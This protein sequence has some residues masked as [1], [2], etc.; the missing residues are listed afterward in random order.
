MNPSLVLIF[1]ALFT[2]GIGEGTFMYFQ[3]I[4][5]QNLGAD[6]VAIGAILSSAGLAM[7]ISH[8]PAGFLSDRIGRRPLLIAAWLIGILAALLMAAASALPLFVVGLLLYG[9]TAFV[10]SPLSSYVTAAR[11]AWS[12]SRALSFT[13]AAFNVGAV[14]GPLTGGW[15]GEHF[16]LRWVFA[17]AAV[18]FVVSTAFLVFIKPQPLDHHD[19]EAPPTDLWNN[20]RYLGFIALVFVIIFAMY[21]PQ[22]LT[23][24][25][26]Q[27]QR[28]LTLQQIGLLG[29]VAALGNALITFAFGSWF[30]ARRGMLFGQVLAATFVLL[31]WRM[32]AFPIYALAY[33]LLGGFR[34]VRPMLSAQ[35][36][37]LVHESQMGLAFGMN[38]TVASIALTLSPILAGL[39][40]NQAPD[41]VYPVSLGA[42]GLALLLTLTFSPRGEHA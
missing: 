10:S 2:W 12:V 27:T 34:A 24:N 31:I 30:S 41:L 8:V 42:I 16:G 25:F 22:P 1:L 38:E 36:R 32:T 17:A 40:Y 39:L 9:F 13:S 11:G 6:P 7:M 23:T 19:P 37:G 14:L 21:L 20:T 5:L 4:H 29:S 18:T 28:G 35:V 26:L 15:I 33:F 3:S